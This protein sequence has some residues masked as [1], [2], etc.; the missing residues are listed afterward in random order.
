MAKKIIYVSRNGKSQHIKLKDKVNDP[1]NNK[2]TT[3]VDP[4]DKVIWQLDKDSGLSEITGIKESDNSK[5]QYKKSQNLFD[6]PVR[7]TKV[8]WEATIL[9]VSPGSGKFQ[10][11]MVG[12]KIAGDDT[13]Y[14]DDPKIQM[15]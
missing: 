1:G 13:E 7:K 11:Y 4:S 10:N 6:G 2:L 12:F 5:T 8:G 14:W 15:N 9:P 3:R